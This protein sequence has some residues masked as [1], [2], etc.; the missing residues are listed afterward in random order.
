[1]EK[2]IL[3]NLYQNLSAYFLKAKHFKE[4]KQA[5]KDMEK[6]EVKNSLLNFRKA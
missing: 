3:F 2:G 6:L 5:V 4:A 1:M